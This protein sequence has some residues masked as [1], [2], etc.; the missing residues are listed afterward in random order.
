MAHFTSMKL[1]METNFVDFMDFYSKYDRLKLKDKHSNKFLKKNR[2]VEAILKL[3]NRTKTYFR[4]ERKNSY[5]QLKE[6]P[7][8]MG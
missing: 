2:Y 1:F 6:I 5:F 3:A 8:E 7:A 4:K